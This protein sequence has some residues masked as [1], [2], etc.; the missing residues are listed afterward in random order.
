MKK[1]LFFFL[2][3]MSLLCFTP[4]FGQKAD[5]RVLFSVD[6]RSVGV[7]EFLTVYNKNN[8]TQQKAT[9]ADLKEYLDLYIKFKLKV[10]E[11]Y[12]LGLDTTEKFRK[13]LDNYRNQL[14]QPYLRDRE[15]SQSLVKEA[16]ER[17]QKEVRA[18]HIMIK[19]A[20][21]AAPKD[22]LAAYKKIVAVHQRLQKG[23]D[24]NTLAQT[25]SEDPSAAE[26]QGDLGYFSAFRMIYPFEQTAYTT[27]PGQYSQPFRTQF[28]YHILKVH[29]VRPALGEIR[30]AHLMLLTRNSDSDS[31]MQNT[32]KRIMEIYKK[33]KNGENFEALVAQYSEDPSTQSQQGVLPWFGT[34]RMV[35][36]FEATAFALAKDGDF[37]EPVQTPY[38][39]HIIKRLERRGIPAFD[40][41]KADIEAKINRD[42][43]ANLNKSNLIA[44]LKTEYGFKE[45]AKARQ[46]VFAKVVDSL[47]TNGQWT[48]DSIW[49]KNLTVVSFADAQLKQSDLANY[50]Q[51]NQ[52]GSQGSDV[53]IYLLKTYE[54]WV[55]ERILAYEDSRLEK[56]HADFRA[57]LQ[58]YREGILL[59]DLTDQLVWS[60][61]VND[62]DGL[63]AWFAENQSRY[64]WN[65][66]AD[67]T[68]YQFAN[69]A[70]AAKGRKL[71]KKKKNTDDIIVKLMNEENPLN[72]KISSGKFEKG[73]NEV[74]DKID[75]KTGLSADVTHN[76]AVYIVKV[77]NLLPAGPKELNEVRGLA[78]SDYQNYLEKSW[79]EA[80]TAKY[81]VV[82]NQ[83][84]LNSIL[85]Q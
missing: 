54:K 77:K 16:Y 82:V 52:Y 15:T 39:W 42:A 18:S 34:G 30:T 66:R 65:D 44:K 33:L 1:V 47:Y 24:F 45:D 38:G 40:K 36:M 28:G 43:R 31:V 67:V 56:K 12:S 32:R 27:A 60:K 69:P 13:E 21:N 59:F 49:K 14:A 7:E 61:A 2:G 62:T 74:V 23:E 35:P 76:N 6:G 73:T 55:E 41:A 25:V 19:V 80:L 85:P 84:T 48:A 8:Y 79:I 10:N 78:T 17:M 50:L 64:Q 3:T 26:N 75:W 11:A 71:L 57:L 53:G 63:K 9:A 51:T 5:D 20:E 4:S 72:V 58:E 81:K 37:S 68:V 22:S 29:D 46:A 83:E 70:Q